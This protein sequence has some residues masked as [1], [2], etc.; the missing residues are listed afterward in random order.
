MIL[1][2]H[3]HSNTSPDNKLEIDQIYIAAVK[4]GLKY[5]CITN[6]H[7]FIENLVTL[8]FTLE[9]IKI[10]KY[11][12][13]F[14]NLKLNPDTKIFFGTEIGYWKDK[15]EEIKKFI[16]SVNF[17]Y[18]LGSVHGLP[19]VELS[20]SNSRFKIENKP[21]LQKQI[22]E[23]YFVKL[24]KAIE[25]K[26]FDIIGHIDIFKKIMPEPDFITLKDKWNEIADLL[27]KHDLGFEINTSYTN[28]FGE[29]PDL[30]VYPSLDVIKLFV[31]K[32]VKKIT[33]GSDTHVIEQ[34]G[35]QIEMVE[36]LLRNL[37]VKQI[38]YF[39][40]RTPVFVDL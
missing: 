14:S 9:E 12:D 40:E 37:G 39:K 24:K 4:K 23:D 22:V 7:E 31:E 38:C 35:K 2:F 30:A 18:V 8:G 36:E 17:D 25:S 27:I 33:I 32:G 13:D 19:G 29:Q 16:N 11:L 28:Y 10:K 20:D 3:L 15:E 5:I 6:H 21:E 34:I 26:L 1:D